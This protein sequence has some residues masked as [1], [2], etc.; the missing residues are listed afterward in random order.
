MYYVIPP[1]NY[2][3]ENIESVRFLIRGQC[4]R[5][6]PPEN[7]GMLEDIVQEVMCRAVKYKSSFKPRDDDYDKWLR[8]WVKTISRR[9]VYDMVHRQSTGEICYRMAISLFEM[10]ENDHPVSE[11][12]TNG[13][14]DTLLAAK[15]VRLASMSPEVKFCTMAIHADKIPI[16]KVLAEAKRSFPLRKWTMLTVEEMAMEGLT[17]LRLVLSR[18]K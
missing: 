8:V 13:V 12:F 15:V 10:D 17:S 14:I 5:Q 4:R 7:V 2:I 6:L 9:T 3:N 18:L 1:D 11:D 16:R